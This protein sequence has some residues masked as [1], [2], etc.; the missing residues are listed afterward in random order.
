MLEKHIADDTKI[1]FGDQY[2]EV[3]LLL[4]NNN[5]MLHISPVYEAWALYIYIDNYFPVSYK[6]MD[7]LIKLILQYDGYAVLQHLLTAITAQRDALG[8]HITA[9]KLRRYN[10]NIKYI[11]GMIAKYG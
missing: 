2:D 1:L 11:E 7:K 3:H 4:T 9:S 10:S 6:K 5:L 8:E